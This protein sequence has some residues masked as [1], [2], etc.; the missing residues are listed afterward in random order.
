MRSDDGA[1]ADGDALEHDD[2]L[3]EEYAVL[4]A[5]RGGDHA[6]VAALVVIRVREIMLVVENRDTFGSQDRLTKLHSLC[7]TDVVSRPNP[8]PLT[9][10]HQTGGHF[11]TM[12]LKPK[13]LADNGVPPEPEMPG[14]VEV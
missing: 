8:A 3:A 1:T 7:R 4:D 5:N 2:A 13:S 10:A 12:N 6:A 9:D 14:A 11:I